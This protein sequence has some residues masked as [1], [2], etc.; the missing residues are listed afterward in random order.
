MEQKD[1]NLN[2]VLHNYGWYAQKEGERINVFNRLNK[3]V[4]YIF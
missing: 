1:N 3:H 4:F 2:E